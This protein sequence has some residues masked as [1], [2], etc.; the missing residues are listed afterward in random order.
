MSDP[1]RPFHNTASQRE[2]AEVL[3]NDTFQS[4]A[5]ADAD[6]PLGRFT[7]HER[8]TVV[9]SEGAPNYPQGPNWAQHDPVPPEPSL[10]FDITAIEPVGEFHEVQ[11]SL[12][13]LGDPATGFLHSPAPH[14]MLVVLPGRPLWPGK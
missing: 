11:K 2:G 12:A 8:A 6:I 3:S 5:I 4:R 13:A 1:Q 10:G 9:G 14:H 7:E